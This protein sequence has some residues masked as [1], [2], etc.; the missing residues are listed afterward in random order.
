MTG[1]PIDIDIVSS[2]IIFPESRSGK[3]MTV[4]LSIMDSTV[5]Y[6]SRC[7]SIWYYDPPSNPSKAN[8]LT[9]DHLQTALSK[10]LNSYP[11]WC[12]R[13]SYA[14][15]KQNCGHTNRYRRVHVTYNSPTDLGVLFVTATSPQVLSDFILEPEI[16]KTSFKAWDDS[17]IPSES[18]FPRTE[19]S[20][21]NEGVPVD[22]PNLVVQLT[23]FVCGGTALSIS[24][25]HSLADAQSLSQFARD[26]SSMAS[27]MLN[28]RTLP[29]LR[30]LFDPSLLDAYAA[31][32]IDAEMPDTS[33]QE[34]ARKLPLHRYDNYIGKPQVKL[35]P[36]LDIVAHLPLS[37]S[38]PIPWN[39]WD[40]HAPV[41]H[42]LLHFTSSDVDGIHGLTSPPTGVGA[43]RISK[44]DA[45][46]SH[47]WALINTARKL[48]PDTKTFLDLSVG[49]RSRLDPPL[50]PS[51]LGSPII[52]AAISMSTPSGSDVAQS[53]AATATQIR[54]L[55]TQF[56]PQN[57]AA[58]LHDAAFEVSPQRLWRCF[59]G[60]K[61]VL[62]TPWLHLKL[63]EVDFGATGRLKHISPIMPSC[64]GLVDVLESLGERKEGHWS[65]NG[66]D[67]SIYLEA[68]AMD[69]LLADESL[70]TA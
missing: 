12:G 66:V 3:P 16:R 70:W 59:L 5:S 55:L 14:R 17:L 8:P 44:L 1:V 41:A 27:A 51:F 19:L 2:S 68:K 60:D 48:P 11:Q 20:L 35:P 7:A 42:R 43:T 47:I 36:D 58:I 61:H 45:L 22:A 49:L 4:P 26:Y 46:L 52:S 13:L 65:R 32:D 69:R 57:T 31:G 29:A 62:L 25:T 6:F 39:E 21:S 9:R 24:I 53:L 54:T 56:T 40:V 67:V 23:T 30:P 33:I 50:P 18:L 64:D 15:Y 63:D 10:T 37:P 28:L 34:K 38:I